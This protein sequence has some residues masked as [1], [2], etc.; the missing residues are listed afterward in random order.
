MTHK[1]NNFLAN[2]DF[3]IIII[4]NYYYIIIIIVRTYN[5]IRQQFNIDLFSTIIFN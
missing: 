5:M 3:D 2:M 1:F 4:F